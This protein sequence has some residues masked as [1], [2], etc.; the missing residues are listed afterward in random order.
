MKTDAPMLAV[1]GFEVL[2]SQM[3]KDLDKSKIV[4]RQVN[5]IVN[6]NVKIMN[7]L[8]CFLNSCLYWFPK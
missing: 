5:A 4:S 2:V 3:T 6:P 7:I 8:T 1:F